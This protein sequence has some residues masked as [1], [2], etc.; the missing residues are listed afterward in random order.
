M[1]LR[2]DAISFVFEKQTPDFPND[3]NDFSHNGLYYYGQIHA[4]KQQV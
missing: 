4:G 2:S 1:H 3:L